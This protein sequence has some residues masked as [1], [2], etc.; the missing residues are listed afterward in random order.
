MIRCKTLVSQ[1]LGKQIL[2]QFPLGNS[3]GQQRRWK[4]FLEPEPLQAATPSIGCA[5]VGGV[6]RRPW[7]RHGHTCRPSNGSEA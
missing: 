6:A 4:G 2:C 5:C 3:F 7:N 1:T